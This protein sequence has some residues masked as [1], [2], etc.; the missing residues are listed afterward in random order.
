MAESFAVRATAA[1]RCSVSSIACGPWLQLAPIIGHAERLELADH[2]L[3]RVAVDRVALLVEGQ[4]DRRPAR[5]RSSD[6]HGRE[7]RL[8]LVERGHR[9]EQEEVDPALEQPL[10]LLAVGLL[11][12]VG[13]DVADRG[14]GL[15][16]R[17]R[18]APATR[19]RP[20]AA[21]R[22][23]RAPSRLIFR[24]WASR[25]CGPSLKR[26]APNVFVSITSAPASRYSS[27]TWRTRPGFERFSS[28]KQRFRK[29]PRA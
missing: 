9:L 13:R 5:R 24:T 29:T 12:L 16:D 17:A 4:A 28:S 25:P 6:A 27:W 1:M 7:R 22:A 19:A 10:G 14:E 8:R 11:R 21:S 3:G 20:C 26:W 2:V 15:A 18:S 23:I